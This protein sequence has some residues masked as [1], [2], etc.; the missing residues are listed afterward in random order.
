ME[1][2][3]PLNYG[4]RKLNWITNYFQRPVRSTRGLMV[5]MRCN[6][7][8]GMAVKIFIV[9]FETVSMILV[10]TLQISFFS[11]DSVFLIAK[12]KIFYFI[13]FNI[14]SFLYKTILTSVSLHIFLSMTA[15]SNCRNSNTSVLVSLS[16]F[17]NIITDSYGAA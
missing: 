15:V 7:S 5:L 17:H 8:M 12:W 6:V 10:Q 14:A 13:S 1:R 2:S 9:F 11:C 4:M 16:T 3:L